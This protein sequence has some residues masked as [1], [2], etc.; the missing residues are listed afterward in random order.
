MTGTLE[1]LNVQVFYSEVIEAVRD[2]SLRVDAGRIVALLGA[3]GAGKSTLLKA[4]SNVLYPE[5][6]KLIHGS[7]RF[8][9]Q[10]LTPRNADQIVAA[11]IVQV[12]EGRR[13][14]E[15]MTVEE[16][17]K[18]GGYTLSAPDLSEGLE[19]VYELFPRVR[20]KRHTM[21]GLLSGGEQQMVAIGRALVGKPRLLILDEPSLGLAPQII[22]DIFDT[23][24]RLNAEDG[25]SIL[26]V[27]QNARL[28]LEI[29]EFAYVMENGRVVLDGPSKDLMNN[30]DIQEFYL[31]QAGG[32]HRKSLRDV[33]H[34]KRR[35]R[36]L[37]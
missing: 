23:V 5:E 26:F 25:L 10:D 36:W 6:G 18:L 28:A 24:V 7:I 16:N 4:I 11:G 9:G 17:L 22:R 2:V 35:K 12:P 33:K 3:N 30:A 21:A 31:G 1:V 15:T 27:E 34:Y 14:F 20:E 13:L 8:E 29:S 32:G 37:A 19:R